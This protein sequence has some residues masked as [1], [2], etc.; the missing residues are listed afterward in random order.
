[1]DSALVEDTDTA[2]LEWLIRALE[3]ARTRDQTKL[4]DYLEAVLD[5]VVFEV[6]SAARSSR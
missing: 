4:V 1:M 6:E 5:D 3:Y 2:T